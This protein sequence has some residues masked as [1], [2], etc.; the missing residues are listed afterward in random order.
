M[1]T[2]SGRR[3]PLCPGSGGA[4]LEG[5]RRKARGP[6]ARGARPRG[7][8][9]VS[10]AQGCV[11][12]TGSPDQNSARSALETARPWLRPTPGSA[13]PQV[14]SPGSRSNETR[15]IVTIR[16]RVKNRTLKQRQFLHVSAKS[17]HRSNVT[18]RIRDNARNQHHRI[19]IL[20]LSPETCA[21]PRLEPGW[22]TGSGNG[23]RALQKWAWCIHK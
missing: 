17:A 3:D 6:A 21:G 2:S 5:T 9:T 22:R 8:S 10:R 4:A 14:T 11:S 20:T 23:D 12:L 13:E 1:E 18:S 15:P 19:N 7:S 16:R